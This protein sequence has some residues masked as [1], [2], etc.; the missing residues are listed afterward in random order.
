[1]SALPSSMSAKPTSSVAGGQSVDERDAVAGRLHLT[2]IWM[3]TS[4]T[5]SAVTNCEM[6]SEPGAGI[7]PFVQRS[8]ADLKAAPCWTVSLPASVS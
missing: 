4:E 3:S 2:R 1:M 5:G 8:A 7:Y 6:I